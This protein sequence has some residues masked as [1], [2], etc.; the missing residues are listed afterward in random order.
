MSCPR[1]K[2]FNPISGRCVNEDGTKGKKIIKNTCKN[3]GYKY[4]KDSNSCYEE[5]GDIV[6][7]GPELYWYIYDYE[8][9]LVWSIRGWYPYIFDSNSVSNDPLT[10]TKKPSINLLRPKLHCVFDSLSVVST[11]TEPLK[12]FEKYFIA[13]VSR[14]NKL[15]ALAYH[16]LLNANQQLI[17]SLVSDL[18]ALSIPIRE[19]DISSITTISGEVTFSKILANI[20][21]GQQCSSIYSVLTHLLLFAK[22]NVNIVPTFPYDLAIH[23]DDNISNFLLYNSQVLDSFPYR[24]YLKTNA[25]FGRTQQITCE[26]TMYLDKSTKDFVVKDLNNNVSI[27]PSYL[28]TLSTGLPQGPSCMS[29][30]DIMDHIHYLV[31]SKNNDLQNYLNDVPRLVY[32]TYYNNIPMTSATY[33]FLINFFYNPDGTVDSFLKNDVKK[34]N[35]QKTL[36]QWLS[37]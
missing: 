37:L 12:E 30:Y 18:E 21:I 4:D 32:F 25:K 26:K 13:D 17:L 3:L 27:N 24:S 2:I 9:P 20:K 10:P 1:G 34:E 28:F 11:Q 23:V 6:T 35:I 15:I 7:S 31:L 8:E 36:L 14:L 22:S 19:L 29:I 33:N 5:V 16:K